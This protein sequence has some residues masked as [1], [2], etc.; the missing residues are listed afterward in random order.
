MA[1]D[2]FYVKAR[3]WELP[4]SIVCI[5]CLKCL[6]EQN[7][8][9]LSWLLPEICFPNQGEVSGNRATLSF[10]Q[11]DENV[12]GGTLELSLMSHLEPETKV[13]PLACVPS[14]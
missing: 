10:A 7:P 4:N 5:L 9:D 13:H 1:D 3:S 11:V 14:P 8:P 12:Y 2:A 6:L